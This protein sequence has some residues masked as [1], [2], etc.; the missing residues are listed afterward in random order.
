M[1]ENEIEKYVASLKYG[2]K[3]RIRK[4]KQMSV[5]SRYYHIAGYEKR[6]IVEWIE[7]DDELDRECARHGNYFYSLR[8]AEACLKTHSFIIPPVGGRLICLEPVK[9]PKPRNKSKL[10]RRAKEGG[11]YYFISPNWLAVYIGEFMYDVLDTLDI[12]LATD[13][14]AYFTGNYYLRKADAQRE[15]NRLNKLVKSYF[16][17]EK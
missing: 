15:C 8:E 16:K 12:N 11:K 1:T 2:K 7:N 14:S 5:P 13:H 17:K 3:W 9:I 4:V 6:A 10:P